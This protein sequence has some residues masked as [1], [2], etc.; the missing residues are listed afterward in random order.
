MPVF[1]V[2]SFKHALEA[3]M[4]KLKIGVI[5]AGGISKKRTIPG[6][7]KAQNVELTAIM[8]VSE[9][10]L[11]SMA[12]WVKEQSGAQILTFTDA[13]ALV[14]CPDVDIVYIGSPVFAHKEQVEL[15]AKY[16]KSVLCEK[17][18]GKNAEEVAEMVK[19][20][21]EAKIHAGTA[22]MM[23]FH[24]YH[25]QLRTMIEEGKFG[26]I[27]SA[28]VQQV[29]W[30]PSMPNT[31]RQIKELGGGGALMDV[32]VH[33]IDLVE[34]I[35]GSKVKQITGFTETRTFDY[36]VD[37]VCNLLIKLENG[38][39]AYIDGAFNEFQGPEGS[40]LEI[41]G[42][43]GTAILRNSVGQVEGGK[44]E[45]MIQGENGW[46]PLKLEDNFT[47]LYTKEVD[48]FAL[49]VLEDTEEPVPIEQGLWIQQ[50]SGAAYEAQES[51][52][53]ITM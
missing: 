44:V 18:L 9:E 3:D 41:Y 12:A 29:F 45:G 20:C 39:V 1:F 43:K 48:A 46:E 53:V 30:Y 4:K 7:L 19:V 42:T 31:W 17:P 49:S 14:E 6:I 10:V 21:R 50:I 16:G 15:C 26:H 38:A 11:S 40:L 27:I 35:V 2:K 34:Y 22:F 33:N 5:G 25:Q 8:D 13:K 52:R 24:T 37:D 28:R 36:N 47:D 23:R 32:G 51:G